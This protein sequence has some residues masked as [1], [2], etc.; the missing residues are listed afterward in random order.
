M[1]IGLKLLPIFGGIRD[2]FIFSHSI[3]ECAE[4]SKLAGEIEEMAREKGH[5]VPGDFTSYLSRDDNYEEPHY[6]K[7]LEDCYGAPLYYVNVNDLL[8]F[9]KHEA[10][11]D[12]YKNRAVW[13]YLRE[14]PKDTEIALFFD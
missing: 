11:L 8:Q 5:I 4:R 2:S 3:I 13:A 1:P 6:G 9:S 7:T 12:N 14:L 10:V